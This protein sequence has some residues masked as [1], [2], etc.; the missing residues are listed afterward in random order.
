MEKGG[1]RLAD[2]AVSTIKQLSRRV[3]A[4]IRLLWEKSLVICREEKQP[5][6]DVSKDVAALPSQDDCRDKVLQ[7]RETYFI[8]TIAACVSYWA[9]YFPLLVGDVR[10]GGSHNRSHVWL[11]KRVS[12]R[13]KERARVRNMFGCDTCLCFYGGGHRE[14]ARSALLKEWKHQCIWAGWTFV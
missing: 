13:W 1:K 6:K 3:D 8:A 4:T 11:T 14:H 7:P 10:Q 5:R 9:I 2:S 12:P